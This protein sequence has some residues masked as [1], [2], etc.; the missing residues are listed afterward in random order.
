MGVDSVPANTADGRGRQQTRQYRST[1]SIAAR[2]LCLVVTC[3]I[4]AGA[5]V[6]AVRAGSCRV[7]VAL[8]SLHVERTVSG[9]L[10]KLGGTWEFDN[11]LQVASGLSFNVLVV[12]GDSFVRLQFPDTG[13]S[14]YLPGL[15]QMLDE[16]LDGSKIIGIE[17]AGSSEQA[18]RFVSMESQRMKVAVPEPSGVGP[19]SVVAYLVIDGDYKSSIIS[20]T[21]TRSLKA[22][23]FGAAGRSGEASR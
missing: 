6:A 21:L 2:V 22:G 1:P 4:V 11:L 16:G 7:L 13:Y 8:G 5:G 20:N 19:V 15:A 9:L 17:A 10:L 18:A 23:D 12:R 3:A 14:G